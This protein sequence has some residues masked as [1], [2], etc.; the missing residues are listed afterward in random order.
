MASVLPPIHPPMGMFDQYITPGGDSLI[1]TEKVF[2]LSGDSFEVHKNQ[3]GKPGEAALKIQ[4]KHLTISGRKTVSDMA[5]NLLFD[6]VK[7]HFHFLHPTLAA[8]DESGKKYLV[9]K[10]HRKLIGSEA[11][12]TLT[13]KDGRTDTLKMNGNWRDSCANIIHVESGAT[14]ARIDR[15]ILNAREL[16]GGAQ[17]YHLNVAPGVDVAL[18]VA[19]CVALD[20]LNNEK[21][22][23]ISF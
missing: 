18:M 21:K 14:V 6:I 11:T 7:E 23:L 12:L 1:L 3:G 17:T 8:Q 22:G 4:G 19:A 13:S 9:I 16:I 15:Q 20:E 10:K 5:G 2:S